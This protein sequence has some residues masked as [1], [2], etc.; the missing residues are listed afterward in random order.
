[1]MTYVM[2]SRHFLSPLLVRM[3]PAGLVARRYE[4]YFLHSG[5]VYRT[6]GFD[7]IDNGAAGAYADI[8]G[9][10]VEVFFHCLLG[11]AALRGFDS[12]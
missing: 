9:G 2:V 10:G 11:C 7:N 1:M 12:G 8:F 4:S 6:Y 5:V 3:Y